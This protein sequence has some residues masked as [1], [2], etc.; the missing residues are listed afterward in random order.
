MT[1]NRKMSSLGYIPHELHGKQVL[2][3]TSVTSS[4]SGKTFGDLSDVRSDAEYVRLALIPNRRGLVV[5]R[6]DFTG[7]AVKWASLYDGGDFTRDAADKRTLHYTGLLFPWM[8]PGDMHIHY[9]CIGPAN[10][11]IHTQQLSEDTCGFLE[12]T[13]FVA[14]G[15]L[16]LK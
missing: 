11:T 8:M 3:V 15:H 4:I 10:W 16:F 12:S 9:S 14:N 7:N 1:K 2:H 13:P 5:T 6:I